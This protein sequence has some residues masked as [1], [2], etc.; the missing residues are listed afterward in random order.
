MVR[1]VRGRRETR[2]RTSDPTPQHCCSPARKAAAGTRWM[3]CDSLQ[4][5]RGTNTALPPT[6]GAEVL[7]AAA[8]AAAARRN[9]F[10]SSAGSGRLVSQGG[11]PP[12]YSV[13]DQVHDLEEEMAKLGAGRRQWTPPNEGRVYI[14][15]PISP[16]VGGLADI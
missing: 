14:Y 2:G 3:L 11:A 13:E 15:Q 8:A 10:A 12:V 1:G 5:Q 7:A 16:Q 6:H 9:P 4:S